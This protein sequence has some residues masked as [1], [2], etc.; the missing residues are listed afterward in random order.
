MRGFWAYS[1]VQG[2]KYQTEAETLFMWVTSL[3]RVWGLGGLRVEGLGLRV[4]TLRL[5]VYDV[6]SSLKLIQTLPASK[7]M[8][9]T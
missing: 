3:R 4:Q 6:A 9:E 5:S 7:A 2:S 1:S 8:P